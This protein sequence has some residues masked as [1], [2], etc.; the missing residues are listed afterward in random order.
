VNFEGEFETHITVRM[1][2][3]ES[4]SLAIWGSSREWSCVHIVLDRGECVSQP[5]L[6]RRQYGVLPEVLAS[7]NACAAE[8]EASGFSPIR[9]KIEAGLQNRDVPVTDAEAGEQPSDRYFEHHVKL[10]LVPGT[11]LHAIV[12]VAKKHD[13]HLSRNARRQRDDGMEERFV[14]QRCRQV[15]RGAARGRLETLLEAL[16][17]L[18]HP[19]IDLEEEF[20]VYDSN[21][22]V[23]AGW[24]EREV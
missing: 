9:I 10:L 20:T 21:A 16:K 1:N 23:D 2:G 3:G 5:M 4:D 18:G 17:S 12:E 8:L 14:T 6:T 24:I 13:A 7:A 11:D 15:G 22:R 19:V